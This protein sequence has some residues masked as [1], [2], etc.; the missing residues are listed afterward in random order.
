[1]KTLFS[2]TSMLKNS[3]FKYTLSKAMAVISSV[4][5]A[6]IFALTILPMSASAG[7]IV[8]LSSESGNTKMAAVD[9]IAQV[10]SLNEATLDQLVSLKGVG[11]KKALAIIAYRDAYGDFKSIDDL[12]NVKGIGM[13]IVA[14]NKERL[15][16]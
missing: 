15:K 3:P 9:T 4:T 10:V 2:T 14:V 12:I 13:K 1:M 6:A 5:L 8:K 7:E 16:I 11:E